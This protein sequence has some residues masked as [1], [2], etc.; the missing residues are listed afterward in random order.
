MI[1]KPGFVIIALG[2]TAHHKSQCIFYLR[3]PATILT[4]IVKS[5]NSE[6]VMK[7]NFRSLVLIVVLGFIWNCSSAGINDRHTQPSN[8]GPKPDWLVEHPVDPNY[9][10]GIGSASKSQFGSEAQKSAQDLALADLASQI[11]V[12]ITS[13]I[14]T[15]L[16]EKG[17]ITEEEYLATARS[18]AVADLEGHEFVDSWQDQSYQYAYYRLSKAKYAEI[19][20]RK[21]QAAVDLSKD[22]FLEGQ[23]AAEAGD[24]STA[25]NASIQAFLP[26]MPYLNEA[27]EVQL[28]G[29]TT[30]LSNEV[31]RFLNTLLLDIVLKPN[32][33]RINGKLARPLDQKLTVQ[34]RRGD[35]SIITNL[36]LKLSF[37]KGAGDLKESIITDA[38]G[39]STI[40]VN[41]I[42]SGE[43]L[44]ILEITVDLGKLLPQEVSPV[45]NSI[46]HSIPLASTEILI[47]VSNP[48]IYLSAAEWYDGHVLSQAQ[49]EPK[50]K[51]HFIQEGFHFVDQAS[52]ADWLMTLKATATPGTEY[53]GMYTVFADVNLSVVDSGTGKEIYKNSLSR[54]K[55][56]D[57]SYMNAANKALTRAADKLNAAILP[58]IMASLK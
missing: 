6:V 38:T 9:Y 13:D 5:L 43:A 30:I 11:T 46:I 14:V 22:Y 15:T 57:L 21:R 44:Q 4:C 48:T 40:L 17:A 1:P 35:G 19:Q 42:S 53:S 26:L 27:L 2:H 45:L 51:Y 52:K 31:H 33:T 39:T 23:A 18:Q 47:K 37:K 12:T 20:A 56:I 58:Q 55:G 49:I 3:G 29:K 32:T 24:F 54:V 41:T 7:I 36:P 34:A 28:D 8:S 10:I 25:L 16:I 50:L